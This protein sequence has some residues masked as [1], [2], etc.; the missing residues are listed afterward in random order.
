MALQDFDPNVARFVLRRT[1]KGHF[2]ALFQATP[3]RKA[4]G[5]V[6][7]QLPLLADSSLSHFRWLVESAAAYHK[8]DVYDYL[9]SDEPMISD[10][11]A[12]RNQ[13]QEPDWAPDI[14][15]A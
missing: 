13:E 7:A 5:D 1:S 8:V 4:E 6:V 15:L 2:Q 9:E 11:S 10:N 12:L 3:G 14:V